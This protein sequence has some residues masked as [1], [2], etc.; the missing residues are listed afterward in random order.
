MTQLAVLKTDDAVPFGAPERDRLT[1]ARIELLERSCPTEEEVIE[2]G[3]QADALMV[4][5]EPITARVIDALERCRVIARFG[6][7]LDNVDVDAASR[8]RIQV[9]YVPG[10]SAEEV[11][12]HTLAML[13]ALARRLPGLDAAVR[14]GQWEI[15]AE[16]PRFRRL[17]GQ[18]LGVIGLGRIG[19]IVAR[20]AKALGL[21]TVVHDPYASA[22]ALAAAGARAMELDELLAISDHVSLHTP[23]TPQTRHLI[24]EREL[25]LMKP[26]AT[27]I[28]VARGGVVDQAALTA[29][30]SSG[31]LAGAGLDVFEQEPPAKDEPLLSLH[32]VILTPHAAHHSKESMDDL[33]DSVIS[34]VIAVLHGQ[35]PRHPVNSLN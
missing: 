31:R 1:Q 16:L 25:A 12:D 26:S 9:T 4:V 28:N 30:L 35:P 34:D 17:R 22:E 6:A 11:S 29:A 21:I 13:L 33:R 32:N 20:K 10:A 2:H 7:G 5:G 27:L 18:T 8:R 23:L 15:P 24:G 19:S 3:A 14:S